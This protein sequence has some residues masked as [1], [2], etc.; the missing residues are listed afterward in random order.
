MSECVICLETFSFVEDISVLSCGH[1]FHSPCIEKWAKTPPTS[2]GVEMRI[3]HSPPRTCPQC[4]A[5]FKLIAP[6]R[7]FIKKLSLSGLRLVKAD[8]YL[9]LKR[10]ADEGAG[11]Q[12]RVLQA[13][14][15]L[16]KKQADNDFHETL[17]KEMKD[18]LREKE[19]RVAMLEK[20]CGEKDEQL[21]DAHSET[22]GFKE[23]VA[24]IEKDLMQ[25]KEIAVELE[26]A[27][28]HFEE[29]MI[30]RLNS[31]RLAESLA[32]ERMAETDRLKEDLERCRQEMC[33]LRVQFQ[34]ELDQLANGT[35]TRDDLIDRLEEQL[36]EAQRQRDAS[37]DQLLT[38]RNL[39]RA[40][41]YELE[42]VPFS[43]V[44][45]R[46]SE[47]SFPPDK[48]IPVSDDDSFVLLDE[49]AECE[50][51]GNRF[52]EAE[53][54][55]PRPASVAQSATESSSCPNVCGDIAGSTNR[56]LELA[57]DLT[58]VPPKM[59]SRRVCDADFLAERANELALD[60]SI[61]HLPSDIDLPHL[62]KDLKSD[63]HVVNSVSAL[64]SISAFLYFKFD[65]PHYDHYVRELIGTLESILKRIF[66]R[67][68]A[69]DAGS[70][71][72]G[73]TTICSA[74]RVTAFLLLGRVEI[75]EA[76]V[77]RFDLASTVMR[78]LRFDVQRIRLMA[79]KL[80]GIMIN[81][82]AFDFKVSP[83]SVSLLSS[84]LQDSPLIQLEITSSLSHGIDKHRGYS[85]WETALRQV[86][87]TE[88]G[89][90]KEVVKSF[91]REFLDVQVSVPP[92]QS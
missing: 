68:P 1:C 70:D 50:D 37:N 20:E 29:R 3:Q 31:Q 42:V 46:D 39:V 8:E 85:R 2:L 66:S 25:S 88:D 24:M 65:S 55:K 45:D 51:A 76:F 72:I 28:C 33:S 59:Q 80:H 81:R 53:E 12:A 57:T 47:E 7:G 52:C 67:T 32:E 49:A 63:V 11:L 4:R 90:L 83:L 73:V 35:K 58:M 40:L 74:L 84:L 23:Q 62:L 5:P 18:T 36:L 6:T 19:A 86:I 69:F 27:R 87:K 34:K 10:C 43:P 92:L 64:D 91:L 79:L 89:R 44:E 78:L 82:P 30:E 75:A 61:T 41:S 22:K 9:S 15:D 17:E 60:L 13:E 71:D 14:T 21:R 16:K 26:R 48:A 56:D 77:Q 38:A 54:E